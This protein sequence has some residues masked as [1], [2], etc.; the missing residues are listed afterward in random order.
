MYGVAPLMQRLSD[1][2]LIV[3]IAAY[4]VDHQSCS[5]KSCDCVVADR[6]LMG[7]CQSQSARVTE[8][9]LNE[10]LARVGGDCCGSAPN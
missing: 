2:V 9:G 3:S 10:V 1:D 7:V 6:W 8:F 5:T 4:A